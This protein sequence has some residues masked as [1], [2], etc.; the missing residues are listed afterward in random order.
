MNCS[1]NAYHASR[2][3]YISRS[4]K[5]Q[6]IS[7]HLRWTLVSEE[8]LVPARQQLI[9]TCARFAVILPS[10][11]YLLDYPVHSILGVMN[12]KILIVE[13]DEISEHLITEGVKI[14]G[15]EILKA[16]TGDQAIEVCRN[17]SDIDL[18]L[19]DIQLPFLGGY[20]AVRE[21]RQFNK[22]VVIIAQTAYGLVGDR[23][24]AIKAGCNDYLSK[25]VNKSEL[26]LLIRKHCSKK[27]R[28]SHGSMN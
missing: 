24:K 14:F 25:P 17:N 21:I 15:K 5:Q 23:E 28:V 3:N 19:M 18:V 8:G 11:M 10:Y 27:F 13:D 20:E 26:H 6:L 1:R 9:V 12:D 22:D 4:T 16:K 7:G 2:A